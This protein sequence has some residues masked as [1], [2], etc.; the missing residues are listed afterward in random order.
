MPPPAFDDDPRLLERVKDLAVQQL[1]AKLRVEALAIAVLPWA[2]RR[3]IGGL[4]ADKRDPVP[5]GLRDE[6]GA[7]VR[8]HMA[9][10]AARNEQVRQDVDDVRRVELAID[11]D[12]QAFSREL[13]DDV[14]HAIF[15]S[16]MG[17]ILDEVV[18][19]DMV[20]MLGPKTD[21]GS[22]IEPETLSLRLPC[23]DLEPLPPPD[24]LDTLDVHDPAGISRQRRDPAISVAAILDRER[25]D[26]GG[27]RRLIVWGPGD[28]ALR[29]AMLAEHAAGEAFGN[30]ERLLNALDTD[31]AAGGAHQFPDAAS[32]RISFS[33]VRSDTAWRS[34]AFSASRSVSRLT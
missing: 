30:A 6:L 3:D 10:N 24:P 31:T 25:D 8:T 23:W 7:V 32:F 28:L 12:G 17:T 26:V 34:R 21:A 11:P 20:R 18:G 15:A 2:A 1:I 16:V 14:Q 19:P 22:V 33:S 4:G 9:G 13:V 29:R 27:Q 5:R